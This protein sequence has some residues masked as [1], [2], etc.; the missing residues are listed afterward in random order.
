M[1]DCPGTESLKQKL[2]D[3]TGGRGR[4]AAMGNDR[5][6]KLDKNSGP[7]VTRHQKQPVS[8]NQ[9]IPR[10]MLLKKKDPRQGERGGGAANAREEATVFKKSGNIIK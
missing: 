6:L 9:I 10:V 3:E 7:M 1:K 4:P 2:A 5:R 8:I